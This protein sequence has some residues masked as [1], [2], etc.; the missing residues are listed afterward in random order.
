M[1]NISMSPLQRLG[2]VQFLKFCTVG[3]SSTIIDKGAL[4]VLMKFI[5]PTA[6]WWICAT[7]SFALGV[8]NGFFWNRRWTFQAHGEGHASAREQYVK[9]I[10]SNLVG[11]LLN[12]VFTKMFL[13]FVT[14]KLLHSVNPPPLHVIIAS[15][16][17]APIVVFWN[18]FANKH[19]T[20]KQNA[21]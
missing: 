2:G 15:L 16:C 17:A 1:D 11:L 21:A 5:L 9:F 20:F 10:F 18:F 14:G 12:L 7:I 6:A 8:S 3:V 13:F 4:W 19:W